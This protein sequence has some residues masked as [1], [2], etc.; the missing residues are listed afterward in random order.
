MRIK[1]Q[2]KNKEYSTA[3]I[4]IDRVQKPMLRIDSQYEGSVRGSTDMHIL[5]N[6]NKKTW[7]EHTQIVFMKL[8]DVYIKD[9]VWSQSPLCEICAIAYHLEL[10]A[11]EAAFGAL[12]SMTC[13]FNDHSEA[14]FAHGVIQGLKFMRTHDSMSCKCKATVTHLADRLTV[15]KFSVISFWM[16]SE[17]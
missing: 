3:T 9:C 14:K 4:P 8:H 15:M 2:N 1:T 10:D 16:K 6:R 11:V 17:F 5:R 12:I 7:V 13:T